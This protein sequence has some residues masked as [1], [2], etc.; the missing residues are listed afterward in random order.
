MFKM[1]CILVVLA[2]RWASAF[3]EN[4]RASSCAIHCES[5]VS[6][7]CRVLTHKMQKNRW[8]LELFLQTRWEL[9]AHILVGSRRGGNVWKGRSFHFV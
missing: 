8:Q 6:V 2:L 5:P 1:G 4:P 3:A 9:I 7:H